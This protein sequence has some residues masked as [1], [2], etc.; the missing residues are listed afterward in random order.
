MKRIQ[1]TEAMQLATERLG[2][3]GI[4]LTVNGNP[5]NTMTIGWGSIGIYWGKPVF[6]VVVRPQRHTF[7]LL[8]QAK[9]FTVSVPTDRDMGAE[10]IY[11]GTK[12]GRDED[13][14]SG[15]GLTALPAQKVSAP[16]IGECGLHFEC[17]VLLTQP[18]T[19]D[20][21]APEISEKI[22]PTKD[23]HI[24][25]FGEIVDCYRTDEE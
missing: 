7:E 24:M 18:M 2:G 17:R 5:A 8:N 13:K 21:M 12:S 25:Y 20:Q 16:I 1:Y 14:F 6:M 23:Y 15:H 3:K 19:E 22:Y 11:A 10:L 9:E 4:F